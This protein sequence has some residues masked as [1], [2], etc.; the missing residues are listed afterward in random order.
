LPEGIFECT[1]IHNL[2]ISKVYHFH[3]EA[4]TVSAVF[5]KKLEYVRSFSKSFCVQ[6]KAD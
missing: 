4:K 2:N 5:P 6:S 1:L 3:L